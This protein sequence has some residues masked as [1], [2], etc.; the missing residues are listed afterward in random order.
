M[1]VN[2]YQDA[3]GHSIVFEGGNFPAG[4]YYYIIQIGERV[5]CEKMVLFK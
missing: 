1:L 3:G 5:E 4:M 2:E